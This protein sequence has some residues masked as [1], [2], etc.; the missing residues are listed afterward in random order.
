MIF[1]NVYHWNYIYPF[2]FHT[3]PFESNN[4][5][6]WLH[7]QNFPQRFHRFHFFLLIPKSEVQNMCTKPNGGVKYNYHWMN[8]ERKCD[9]PRESRLTA[10]CRRLL[11]RNTWRNLDSPVPQPCN[12]LARRVTVV[13]DVKNFPFSR[14]WTH[15]LNLFCQL[16][17]SFFTHFYSTIFAHFRFIFPWG[18]VISQFFRFFFHV[19]VH[20]DNY[21]WFR[22]IF[23]TRFLIS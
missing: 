9:R 17:Y 3:F 4:M 15:F 12:R 13:L 2:I 14:F 19:D 22:H 5:F 16:R 6:N 1:F 20:Y 8:Y 7:F 23:L 11:C 10:S 21:S 18:I